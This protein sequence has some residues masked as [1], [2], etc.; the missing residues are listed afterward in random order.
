MK[1]SKYLLISCQKMM[2][3]RLKVYL[4]IKKKFYIEGITILRI[5]LCLIILIGTQVHAMNRSKSSLNNENE[6]IS[7]GLKHLDGGQGPLYFVR[8]VLYLKDHVEIVLRAGELGQSNNRFQT[9]LSQFKLY[10]KFDQKDDEQV[11]DWIVRAAKKLSD[12][13][14]A[15]EGDLFLLNIK[16]Y[17]DLIHERENRGI[18]RELGDFVKKFQEISMTKKEYQ[19]ITNTDVIDI[20]NLILTLNEK[21]SHQ[22][23][24]TWEIQEVL[25][26][27]SDEVCILEEQWF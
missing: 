22:L 6:W 13:N 1:F 25:W 24:K 17:D 4:S 18:I 27:T 16:E 23:F 19:K 12:L 21:K 14:P 26:R 15:N 2:V 20:E 5:A 7:L 9:Y 3:F 8:P 10:L 11:Y